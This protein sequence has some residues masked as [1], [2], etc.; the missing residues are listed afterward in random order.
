M[1]ICVLSSEGEGGD[2]FVLEIERVVDEDE[3]A[4]APDIMELL[5]VEESEDPGPRV[6]NL[7]YKKYHT[8]VSLSVCKSFNSTVCSCGQRTLSVPEVKTKPS[9]P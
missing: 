7:R 9:S 8:S 6:D 5:V 3:A 4:A 2:L 1:T